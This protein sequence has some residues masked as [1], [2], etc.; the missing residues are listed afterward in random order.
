M[1]VASQVNTNSTDRPSSVSSQVELIL[2]HNQFLQNHRLSNYNSK[3]PSKSNLRVINSMISP[4]KKYINQRLNIKMFYQEQISIKPPE[5]QIEDQQRVQSSIKDIV[6][7]QLKSEMSNYSSDTMPYTETKPS[8]RKQIINLVGVGPERSET[9]DNLQSRN[10][11]QLESKLDNGFKNCQSIESLN[12]NGSQTMLITDK[13][14]NNSVQIYIQNNRKSMQTDHNLLSKHKVNLSSSQNSNDYD[15]NNPKMNKNQQCNTSFTRNQSVLHNNQNQNKLNS[16]LL[17]SI[18]LNNSSLDTIHSSQSRIANQSILHKYVLDS[19]LQYPFTYENNS[20]FQ[21]NSNSI[22]RMA[23]VPSKLSKSF[24]INKRS[25]LRKN[26]ERKLDPIIQ[27]PYKQISSSFAV[28]NRDRFG[29]PYVPTRPQEIKPGPGY[30]NVGQILERQ[31]NI[32]P[33]HGVQKKIMSKGKISIHK[34]QN[35]L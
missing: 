23:A 24:L 26:F 7:K 29:Q 9:A 21:Y 4:E 22:T 2:D 10:D 5:N 18:K 11:F 12:Q 27:N 15:Q 3:S 14:Q 34:A 30:Y 8:D 32:S 31:V 33:F 1:R 19:S 35:S 6:M 28:G 20:S 17:P 25:M 16:Q 13:I